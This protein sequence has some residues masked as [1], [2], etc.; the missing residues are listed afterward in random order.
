MEIHITQLM[1]D[2]FDASLE[3]TLL[4]GMA[5]VMLVLSA[6][7]GTFWLLHMTLRS[8]YW[9]FQ[10]MNTI[11]QEVVFE[12]AKVAFICSC[13]FNL[14]WYWT[15]IVP[16]V[17]GFPSW[18][19]G[20]LS[21]Q[22]G[23]QMN[24]IDSMVATYLDNLM[25]LYDVWKINIWDV[26]LKTLYLG[27]QAIVIYLVAGVP[28]ML[29]VSGTLIVLKAASTAILAVGPL[30]IAFSLFS[31]TRH[32]FW[33]WVSLLAG[34]MLTQVLFSMVMA[35]EMSF[36]NGNIIKNGVID[37]S[38]AGNF[39]MFLCFSAFTVLAV[40]LPNYGASI[41]GGSPVA[42]TGISGLLSKGTGIH[43]AMNGARGA[44]QLIDKAK[45]W[46]RNR[47]N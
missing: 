37:T 29:T 36:I 43:A 41:M 40:E 11:F 47:I 46:R 10:G 1:Y 9:L 18:M 7:I 24:Q 38:L 17:T 20:V 27:A 39:T 14:Q 3:S 35:L 21:G 44:K 31:Q 16:F 8:I 6:L 33:G 32:W 23:S 45:V 30:L 13:A 34:F 4:N 26:D 2:F 22:E 12:I 42:A 15:T 25:Q 19:G 28:F 5:K